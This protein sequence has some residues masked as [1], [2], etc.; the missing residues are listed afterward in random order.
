M[1]LVVEASTLELR[2]RHHGCCRRT[3]RA[4]N[5]S[6]FCCCSFGNLLLLMRPTK[7][8]TVL[9][10]NAATRV[11]VHDDDDDKK[12]KRVDT[13]IMAPRRRAVV[14][15]SD[16]VGCWKNSDDGIER[17]GVGC[18]AL[19]TLQLQ[20]LVRLDRI[21]CF[22]SDGTDTPTHSQPFSLQKRLMGQY[23][24]VLVR[25]SKDTGKEIFLKCE[26]LLGSPKLSVS[27]EQHESAWFYCD[28]ESVSRIVGSHKMA[29]NWKQ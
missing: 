16:C 12:K 13:I 18:R 9:L 3:G 17:D 6:R 27:N 28:S 21:V 29:S 14:V 10:R 25:V 19:N 22:L 7:A 5:S 2:E 15:G 20:L 11:L 8:L 1:A 4:A 26:T 24:L 23:V